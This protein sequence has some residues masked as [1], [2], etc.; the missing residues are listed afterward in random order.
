MSRSG[1][2]RFDD[3][4]LWSVVDL[5]LVAS[6][7]LFLPQVAFKAIPDGPFSWPLPEPNEPN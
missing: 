3:G 4:R 1:V 7:L 2:T 6:A 5:V